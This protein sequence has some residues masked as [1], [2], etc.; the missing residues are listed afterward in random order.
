MI[1]GFIE[2]RLPKEERKRAAIFAAV[3]FV[4]GM[5]MS[6]FCS[7]VIT[8]S[9]ASLQERA[10]FPMLRSEIESYRELPVAVQCSP[11]VANTIAAWNARIEHEHESNRHWYSDGFSTDR[12][13][14]V[15]VIELRC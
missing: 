14:A 1:P 12:W 9:L 2:R 15:S 4:A 6:P 8:G 3:S 11:Q 7:F 5:M 13:N 10:T